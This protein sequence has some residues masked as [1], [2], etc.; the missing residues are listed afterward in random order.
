[1]FWIIPLYN[2]LYLLAIVEPGSIQELEI[3]KHWDLVTLTMIIPGLGQMRNLHKLLLNDIHII[4]EVAQ[5]RSDRRL[6]C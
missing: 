5:K 3:Y 2:P 6:V 4:F 1:M